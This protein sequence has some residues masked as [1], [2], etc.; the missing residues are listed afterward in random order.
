MRLSDVGLIGVI[1]IMGIAAVYFVGIEY[2]EEQ[3]STLTERLIKNINSMTPAQTSCKELAQGIKELPS[4]LEHY[5]D[6][7]A[8]LTFKHKEMDCPKILDGI[9]EPNNEMII[10]IEGLK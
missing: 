3:N 2:Q 9:V 5:D 7:L 10:N 8:A 1:V 4:T 6:V